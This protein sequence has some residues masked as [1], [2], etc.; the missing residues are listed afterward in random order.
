MSS[1]KARRR[2][3][4]DRAAPPETAGPAP[5]ADGDLLGALARTRVETANLVRSLQAHRDQT[6]LL[7]KE[8]NRQELDT[9]RLLRGIADILDAFDRLLAHDGTDVDSYRTSVRRTADVLT[10]VLCNHSGLELLGK[11]G[12]VAEPATHNVVE[13]RDKP[14]A[15]QDTVIRVIERGIRYRGDLLRPASVIVASGREQQ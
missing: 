4:S 10:D 8:I 2:R 5:S 15:P 11:P 9:R 12:E 7:L 13:V 1:R 6:E 3:H 14:G